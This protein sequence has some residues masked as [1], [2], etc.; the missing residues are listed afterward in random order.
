MIG[1]IYYMA[2]EQFTGAEWSGATDIYAL[3]VLFHEML[4]GETPFSGESTIE[5]LNQKMRAPVIEPIKNR[6]DVPDQLKDTV[7]EMMAADSSKR[8][9]AELLLERLQRICL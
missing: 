7:A 5:I 2:P 1:T 4:T 3:G 8:P 6:P 9:S